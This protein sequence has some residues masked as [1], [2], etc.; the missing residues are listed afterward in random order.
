MVTTA[1]ERLSAPAA[2]SPH[3][4]VPAPVPPVPPLAPPRERRR[5][6]ADL[7]V[8]VKFAILMGTVALSLGAL[9]TAVVLG[10]ATVR[11][12]SEQVALQ[13]RAQELVLLLDTRASELKVS[14]YMALVRDHPEEQLVALEEDTATAEDILAQLS[15]LPLEAALADDVANLEAAFGEYLTTTAAFIDDAVTDPEATAA[16]WGEVQDANALTDD[17]VGAVADRTKAATA[18]AEDDLA[19]AMAASQLASLLTAVIG[20]LVA[21]GISWLTQRSVTRPVSRMRTALAAMADGDLTVRAEVDS[22]D[23]VGQM[24]RALDTAQ[25]KLRA[26]VG[27]V[28]ETAQAVAAA[29]EE[30]SAGGA[31]LG[32][33][34]AQTSTQAGVVAA[35]AEEVSSNVQTVAAGAEQMGASIR[36]IAQNANAAAK[37]ADRATK[38]AVTTN[39]TVGKLGVSSQQIG[40]VVKVITSI[41]EQ[42]NL[43]ALNA[44]IEAARAGEAGKGFAVVA[45]EVKDLA[46][47]T[48]RATEDI[49]RRVAAIQVDTAGAVQAI[50][51]ISRIVGQIND[52]Q[53]TIASAVEEQTATTNEMSRSVTEVATGSGQIASTITGVAAEASATTEILS[54]LN[55]AAGELARMSADLQMRVGQFTH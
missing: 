55:D 31:Q 6:F 37:V 47:E 2:P 27:E 45:G 42:T 36:E 41:A 24:A 26:L 10:N 16:R 11:R 52:Y 12:G 15:A 38:V 28:S 25:T 19:D 51:E 13:E 29:S 32:S 33:S 8:G 48:A 49:A 40:D 43:L 5:R 17:A 53:L 20:L 18:A 54:Q 14:A 21:V 35:A 7:P 46:Q 9:V 50:E 30:L 23:E 3:R 22:A 44:T 4:T 1:P 34:S 39:E